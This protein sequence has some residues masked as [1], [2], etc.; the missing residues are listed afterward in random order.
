MLL[1][2]VASRAFRAL[3]KEEYGLENSPFVLLAHGAD[4]KNAL[5]GALNC[6]EYIRKELVSHLRRCEQW[7]RRRRLRWLTI[8]RLIPQVDGLLVASGGG[9]AR[10][11]GRR[12][13]PIACV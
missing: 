12:C 4:Y 7:W 10:G 6:F 2:H 13:R 8:R 11:D 9:D 3:E 1:E 5:S